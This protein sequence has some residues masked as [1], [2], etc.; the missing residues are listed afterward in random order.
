MYWHKQTSSLFPELEWNK[1][2]RRNQ[3]G[4]LL[5]IG[6]NMHNLSAPS[7]SFDTAKRTGI[8]DIHLILPSKTKRL[9]AAALPEAYFLPS[10]YSGEFSSKG[11][12]ELLE[13]ALWADT[14]LIPGNVGR[15]SQT[16]I[17]LED[18]LRS[19]SSRVVLSCDSIDALA[20]STQF[21][22]QRKNTTLVANFAQL[23]SL[24]KQTDTPVAITY[25]MDLTRIVEVLHSVTTQFAS[26]IVTLHQ[27]QLLVASNGLVSSTKVSSEISKSWRVTYASLASCFQTWN[28]ENTFK[29]LTHSAH[30]LA[31]T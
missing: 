13:H 4:R 5:I 24:I 27:N 14:V 20:S 17:L 22:L 6:G 8:G 19:Y 1:P 23:Q 3:A 2:E 31:T 29:A 26:D 28:P 21:L 12:F 25:T 30:C 16:S 18:L 15:N 11:S 7:K 10:T 9:V